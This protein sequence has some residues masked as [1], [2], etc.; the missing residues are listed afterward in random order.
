MPHTLR[1]STATPAAKCQRASAT[2]VGFAGL[3]SKRDAGSP[4]NSGYSTYERVLRY[5]DGHTRR[6]RYPVEAQSVSIAA[7]SDVLDVS[8]DW[9]TLNAFKQSTGSSTQTAPNPSVTFTDSR[10]KKATGS[11]DAVAPSEVCVCGI[12]PLIFLVKLTFCLV[13]HDKMM[14]TTTTMNNNKTQLAD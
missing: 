9:Q 5:P 12:Y 6:I 2:V 7:Q 13:L 10:R 1:L 3:P 14:I 4:S 8:E 11:R